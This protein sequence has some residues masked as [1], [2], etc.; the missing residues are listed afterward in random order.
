MNIDLSQRA[1]DIAFVKRVTTLFETL[2]KDID[3]EITNNLRDPKSSTAVISFRR[4]LDI[5]RT[6]HEEASKC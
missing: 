5:A 2:C 1:L 4:H 6:A 3:Q